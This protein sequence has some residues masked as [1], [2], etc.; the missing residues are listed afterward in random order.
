[1]SLCIFD[2][3]RESPGDR[4]KAKKHPKREAVDKDS[5]EDEDSEDD[6]EE[7]EG[8]VSILFP[9]LLESVCCLEPV[10]SC[11]LVFFL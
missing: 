4:K 1:M 2:P 5:D 7:V 10:T 9:K 11:H 3:Y 6:W 8:N